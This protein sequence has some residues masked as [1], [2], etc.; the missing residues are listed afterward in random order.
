[1][2]AP[3]NTCCTQNAV[4]QIF[5]RTQT[6][7]C[8]RNDTLSL[9]LGVIFERMP[10]RS[11]SLHIFRFRGTNSNSVGSDRKGGGI[12]SL[13]A[14]ADAATQRSARSKN[15][16]MVQ[17]SCAGEAQGIGSSATCQIEMYASFGQESLPAPY[18]SG[19]DQGTG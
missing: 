12:T 10:S 19:H 6:L 5:S 13:G 16:V 8:Q 4:K 9:M 18:T 11:W 3:N 17:R 7:H 15:L 2:D 1:M 14:L